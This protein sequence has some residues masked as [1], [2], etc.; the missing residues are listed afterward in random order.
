M[1]TVTIK[2]NLQKPNFRDIYT[3]SCKVIEDTVRETTYNKIQFL[4]D[5]MNEPDLNKL[6]NDCDKVIR[7]IYTYKNKG[8]TWKDSTRKAY[9]TDIKTLIKYRLLNL[10]YMTIYAY[11]HPRPYAI[12]VSSNMLLSDLIQSIN[13]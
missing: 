12:H 6:F 5:S 2:K 4:S 3:G 9:F 10:P 13:E 7:F 11:L 8:I 1:T